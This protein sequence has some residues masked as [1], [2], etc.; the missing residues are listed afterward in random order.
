[1]FTFANSTERLFCPA[2]FITP[3]PSPIPLPHPP[4][5]PT[6]P[7]PQP[8]PSGGTPPTEEEIALLE[9][10]S[11]PGDEDSSDAGFDN[12]GD[13]TQ[14]IDLS[15]GY[16]HLSSSSHSRMDP[17]RCALFSPNELFSSTPPTIPNDV[18]DMATGSETRLMSVL[19]LLRLLH[20][21]TTEQEGNKTQVMETNGQD[22]EVLDSLLD[23]ESRAQEDEYIEESHF[24]STPSEYQTRASAEQGTGIAQ[25]SLPEENDS[26][27]S[28]TTTIQNDFT[29][30]STS[31]S[32]SSSSSSQSESIETSLFLSDNAQDLPSITM[33][34][35][36]SFSGDEAEVP[37]TTQ[38][39]QGI[40]SITGMLPQAFVY[41]MIHLLPK[42]TINI[43]QHVI[44][45]IQWFFTYPLHPSS[46]L[47]SLTEEFQR[48]DTAIPEDKIAS[49]ILKVILF[50][51]CS[52]S[53]CE[54][55]FSRARFI[56]GKRRYQ[57]SRRA[58]FSSLL[59]S[60]LALKRFLEDD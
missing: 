44:P 58:L 43:P 46:L 59:V 34:S 42:T 12:D 26:D 54:R 38:I 36:P 45:R 35:H 47:P 27:D 55:L 56:V 20:L 14:P 53:S 25:P 8:P 48:L 19:S 5:P 32:S 52:E 4:P 21:F 18:L 10:L 22:D 30:T 24:R 13:G 9:T 15:H 50:S 31:S 40:R 37:I 2:Q 7:T 23:E 1:M 29:T 6:P 49:Q 11:F 41:F 57:L 39:D 17:F 16:G 33:V 51:S 3:A 60:D 28:T